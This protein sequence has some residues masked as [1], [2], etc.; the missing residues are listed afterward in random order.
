MRL[1]MKGVFIAVAASPFWCCGKIR[2]VLFRKLLAS[3]K[4][5]SF[6]DEIFKVSLRSQNTHGEQ[7]GR[8]ASK[9]G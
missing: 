7:V 2:G 6:F 4:R 3:Y 1:S 8:S 5:Q 9:L